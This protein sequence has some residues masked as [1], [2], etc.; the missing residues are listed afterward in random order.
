MLRW[1]MTVPGHPAA[2]QGLQH[3][4]RSMPWT[5]RRDNFGLFRDLFDRAP[6]DRALEG[7]GTQ[8]SWLTSK[9]HS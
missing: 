2:L 4:E 8:G 7:S 6:W 3:T 5:Y 1:S 9:D